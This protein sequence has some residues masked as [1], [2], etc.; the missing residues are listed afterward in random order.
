MASFR[1]Q[2]LFS[3]AGDNV[4]RK[5]HTISWYQQSRKIA[6]QIDD[7]HVEYIAFTKERQEILEEDLG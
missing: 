1:F 3:L 7:P 5:G 2:A 6:G 4:S